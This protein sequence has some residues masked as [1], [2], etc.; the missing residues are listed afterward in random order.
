MTERN[1]LNLQLLWKAIEK[2]LTKRF[3]RKDISQEE[4]LGK[5]VNQ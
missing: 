1:I 4:D 3:L 5:A 2:N